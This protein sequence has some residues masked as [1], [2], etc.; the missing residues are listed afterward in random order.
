MGINSVTPRVKANLM[1]PGLGWT[2]FLGELTGLDI[3]NV[4]FRE[5][6]VTVQV[7]TLLLT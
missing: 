4:G 1:V 6:Q 5:R 7:Q 2:L 3:K